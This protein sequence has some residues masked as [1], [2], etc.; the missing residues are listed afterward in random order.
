MPIYLWLGVREA[1][2]HSIRAQL[3]AAR[4][5]AWRLVPRWVPVHAAFVTSQQVL[6]LLLLTLPITAVAAFTL[7]ISSPYV[8]S[9]HRISP[10]SLLTANCEFLIVVWNSRS[11]YQS[12]T[13]A[14]RVF[15]LSVIVWAH[16]Q[17]TCSSPAVLC[18]GS[19]MITL[20]KWNSGVSQWLFWQAVQSIPAAVISYKCRDFIVIV[21]SWWS[22]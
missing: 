2:L 15:H 20:D 9:A 8:Q 13:L 11:R 3:S 1:W 17:L 16:L 4:L 19:R 18:Q 21:L 14:E 10:V 7:P 22:L 12:H 6:Y 5:P